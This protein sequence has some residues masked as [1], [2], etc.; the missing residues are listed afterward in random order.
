MQKMGDDDGD[1]KLERDF[2]WGFLAWVHGF[3]PWCLGFVR[4][5]VSEF[6]AVS[7]M[8]RDVG[9]V[10]WRCEG[11]MGFEII[12]INLGLGVRGAGKAV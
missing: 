9:R 8:M 7:S 10:G 3:R 4:G 1:E 5:D 11:V 2:F 6:G 12:L